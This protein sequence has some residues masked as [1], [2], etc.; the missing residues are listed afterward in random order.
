[1]DIAALK[2]LLMAISPVMVFLVALNWYKFGLKH[3]LIMIPIVL[4]C[5]LGGVAVSRW[6]IFSFEYFK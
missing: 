1:M 2:S 3:G 5:C 6:L 4:A